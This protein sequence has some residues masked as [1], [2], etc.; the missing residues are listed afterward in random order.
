MGKRR[1]LPVVQPDPVRTLHGS[2]PVATLDLHGF[3]AAQGERRVRDLV[4]SWRRRQPGA[5]L[6]IVTGKGRRS[7]AAPVHLERVPEL[8]SGAVGAEVEEFV[9]EAGGG[10][11]L[12]RLRG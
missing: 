12:V 2:N 7:E 11:Y 5:V 9:L 8:L 6:R 3:T 10:S 1:K 4:E